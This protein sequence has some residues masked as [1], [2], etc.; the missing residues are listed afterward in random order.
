[1]SLRGSPDKEDFAKLLAAV[2]SLNL[3]LE[4]TMK[5]LAISSDRFLDEFKRVVSKERDIL[6]LCD[7]TRNLSSIAKSTKR[8]KSNLSKTLKRLERNGI[9]YVDKQEDGEKYYKCVLIPD[10][11]FIYVVKKK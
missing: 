7:G 11:S 9:I 5:L 1:M 6:V 2:N 8:D 3:K 4:A 10:N